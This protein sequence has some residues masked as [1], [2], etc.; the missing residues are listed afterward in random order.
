[1]REKKNIAFNFG[2]NWQ[3]FS[4][5]S[6]DQTQFTSA[7]ESL[8]Q[9]IGKYRITGKSFLDIGCGSGLF[10]ISAAQLGAHKV[11]GI[12]ISRQSISA[13]LQNKQRSAPQSQIEF[14][15]R[16]IFDKSLS[17]LGQFDIVYAWGVLHHTGNMYQALELAAQMVKLNG[18]LAIA[19]YNRHWSSPVWKIIK[20]FY[21]F[22]PQFIQW[23]M[24][25]LFYG[26]IALA[27]FIVTGKNP[28]TNK[29]RGMNFFYDVVD[30][31]G[32]YPYEYASRKKM[33]KFMEKIG[34][35]L[36]KFNKAPVP[37]G[38]NEFV[39]TRANHLR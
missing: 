11:V 13:S 20:R 6:L 7:L 16:S 12:D 32:G 14:F 31:V 18:I 29:R 23:L 5:H 38:C 8:D 34:F 17:Q 35:D 30:W 24:I 4:E 21:N 22:A 3:D 27:K 37:T 9:L 25:R 15:H 1:M 26:I 19:I 2:K 36:I 10:A 39:F 33:E 28:F